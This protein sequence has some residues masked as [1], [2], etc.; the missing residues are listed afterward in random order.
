MKQEMQSKLI[1]KVCGFPAPH[2]DTLLDLQLPDE[3]RKLE[4]GEVVSLCSEF[5]NAGTHTT[6]TALQWIMANLV[7]YPHIHAR[8]FEE[9]SGVMGER[10][11]KVK[12]EDLQKLP[13]LKAVILEGLRHHPP[14][15]FGMPH[16]VSQDVALGGHDIPQNASIYF[17]VAEIGWNSNLWE[18]P[19]EFKPERFLNG[20][21]VKAFDV[22]R[23]KEIKMMSFG[24]RMRICPGYGLGILHLEYFVANLIWKFKWTAIDGDDVDLSEKTVLALMPV[25]MKNPLKAPLAPRVIDEAEAD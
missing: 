17:M 25:L 1:Q 6:Y 3:K 19:V 16:G 9:I 24:A 10:W 14:T 22:T 15:H 20:D 21:G 23:S 11:D 13:Y 4:D 2:I 12:E 18:D 8:L 5:L 7:K